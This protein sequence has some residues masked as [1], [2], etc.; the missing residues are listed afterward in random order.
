LNKT[1]GF[2]LVTAARASVTQ[3]IHGPVWRHTQLLMK[4]SWS[5]ILSGMQV[6]LLSIKIAMY[7][8][9]SSKLSPKII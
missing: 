5:A 2:V 3:R 6:S 7:L 8:S 4:K 9:F 1:G